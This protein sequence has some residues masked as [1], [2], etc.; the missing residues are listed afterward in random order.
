MKDIWAHFPTNLL[1]NNENFI[2]YDFNLSDFKEKK[3]Y[4]FQIQNRSEESE[5][6]KQYIDSNSDLAHD[7]S[8]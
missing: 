1:K 6:E 8:S 3:H 4:I 7:R 5:E 2:L